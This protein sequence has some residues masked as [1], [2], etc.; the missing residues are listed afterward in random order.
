MA[1][2]PGVADPFR[3]AHLSH[4]FQGEYR[5]TCAYGD[6]SCPAAAYD[7]PDHPGDRD[8]DPQDRAIALVRYLAL[9]TSQE[10]LEQ[11]RTWACQIALEMEN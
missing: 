11:A 10:E 5:H 8:L 4:C 6:D 2:E 1:D 3:G 7:E 9:S